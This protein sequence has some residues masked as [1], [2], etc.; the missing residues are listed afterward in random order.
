MNKGNYY[1]YITTNPR[2]TVFYTGITNNL[3]RRELEHFENRGDTRYFASKYYCYK[4]LYFEYF[5]DVNLAIIR[6]KGIKKMSRRVKED[7]IK[8]KNPTME[9]LVPKDI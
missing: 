3:K 5:S 7:L 1:V 8:S 9:F 6:E 4:L 2:K